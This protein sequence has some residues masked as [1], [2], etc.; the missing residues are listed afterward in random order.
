MSFAKFG[1]ITRCTT[2]MTCWGNIHKWIVRYGDESNPN[3][4]E[5][6]RILSTENITK[7]TP[8]GNNALHFAAIAQSSQILAYLLETAPLTLIDEPNDL[9]E[10]PLHWACDSGSISHVE[11]LVRTGAN[12]HALDNES[13]T[14]L[15]FAAQAGNVPVTKFILKKNLCPTECANIANKTPLAV[16]CEEREIRI[17]RALVRSG[18]STYPLIRHYASAHEPKIVKELSRET[19]LK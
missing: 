2:T 7:I 16:A 13:N 9:G 19:K 4:H 3:F 18:A 12:C 1:S 17:V 11:L 15:H 14:I 5:L 10:T 8:N 6:E